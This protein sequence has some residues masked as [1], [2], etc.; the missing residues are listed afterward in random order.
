MAKNK[1]MHDAKKN[2]NDG[3]SIEQ[4]ID[5][6]ELVVNNL[7][8]DI[9]E[10]KST[11]PTLWVF[12][13]VF[14]FIFTLITL[15]YNTHFKIAIVITPVITFIIH[16]FMD[17]IVEKK[18]NAINII[19]DDMYNDLSDNAKK[20][21]DKRVIEK[22]NKA[23]NEIRENLYSYIPTLRITDKLDDNDISYKEITL[24][25]NKK[26]IITKNGDVYINNCTPINVSK[27]I[28]IEPIIETESG[29]NAGKIITG[30]LLFG[31]AG[32]IVGALSKRKDKIISIGLLF[33]INDFNKPN[34]EIIE[35]VSYVSD[36][37]K[38]ELISNINNVISTVKVLKENK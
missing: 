28:S 3:L 14:C 23:I 11:I 13:I 37:E 17:N 9:D 5:N 33:L 27:I 15:G 18:E 1:N 38:N 29:N 10:T 16:C 20:I 6:Y 30:G 2:K 7:N 4:E 31:G 32:A 24:S 34:I 21:Y 26:I 8:K 36:I 12:C 25:I 22:T 19:K 35:D